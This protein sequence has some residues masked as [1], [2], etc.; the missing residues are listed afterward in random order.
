MRRMSFIIAS[1]ISLFGCAAMPAS[2]ERRWNS[3]PYQLLGSQP[4]DGS[5]P[6]MIEVDFDY[7]GI[8][9][10][11]AWAVPGRSRRSNILFVNLP[12]EEYDLRGTRSAFCFVKK[13]PST[14]TL[15][16][17][18][19]AVGTVL[20]PLPSSFPILFRRARPAREPAKATRVAASSDRRRGTDQ[21]VK[22]CSKDAESC[23][24]FL[25]P[26]PWAALWERPN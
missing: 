10:V 8:D 1:T 19:D 18:F 17:T 9:V 24:I 5:S 26:V 2:D 7:K 22:P 14:Q 13:D 11:R 3:G 25:E 12:D 20:K 6:G 15:F 4:C 16:L 21:P 23:V